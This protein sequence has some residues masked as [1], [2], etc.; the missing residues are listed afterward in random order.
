MYII[1]LYILILLLLLLIECSYSEYGRFSTHKSDL[2]CAAESS[3]SS[4]PVRRKFVLKS[5]VLGKNKQI[6]YKHFSDEC[7]GVLFYYYYYFTGTR[8][9]ARY[10]DLF[11]KRTVPFCTSVQTKF[12]YIGVCIIIIL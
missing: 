9:I 12:R 8:I 3:S 2:I 5:P 10:V 1:Y 6:I 11:R 4:S 7:R